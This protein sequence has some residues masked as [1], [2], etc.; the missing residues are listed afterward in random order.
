M[1]PFDRLL[2]QARQAPDL[3]LQAG[4]ERGDLLADDPLQLQSL[5]D[6]PVNL[7][8]ISARA[9]DLIVLFEVG[10][11]QAYT[12]R[13]RHPVWPRGRSGVTCGIGYDLGYVTTSTLADD[14]RGHTSDS[15]IA[16]LRRACGVT[17]TAAAALVPAMAAVDIPFDAAMA[18]FRNATLPQTIARTVRALPN[19]RT[20]HPDS[21]GALVSLVYNRG[22]SFNLEG[23]RYMEMRQIR[24]DVAAWHFERVPGRIRAMK[25]IWAGDPDA[26]GLLRRRELEAVLFEAGLVTVPV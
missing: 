9:I 6:P 25:R 14:W 16:L 21:L 18:V 12:S 13:Y 15:N 17:G 3:Q 7:P 22:A 19:A 26:R 1:D 4:K 8:A 10:G 5:A 11:Q 24:D 20:M 2:A 23:E